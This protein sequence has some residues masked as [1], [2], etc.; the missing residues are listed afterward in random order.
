MSRRV[1]VAGVVLAALVAVAALRLPGA[2]VVARAGAAAPGEVDL[3]LAG[4]VTRVVDGDTA[5]VRV[6][7]GPLEVRFYGIDA[8]EGR[9]PFGREAR[10]ALERRIAGRRVEIVPVEQDQYARMVAVVLVDGASVNEA[11]L[12]D[13]LAWAYRN[14]LGQVR[15][16]ENFC[17]L[18]DRARAAR[19]GLWSQPPERWVPPWVYRQ[20]SRAAPGAAFPS[21]DYANETAAD[22]AAAVR[23]ARQRRRA[24]PPPGPASG[25]PAA[26]AAADAVPADRRPGCDI[27]GN[28]N[29]KG[30]RIYHL[31]GGEW[32][33]GTRID[34]ARGE[35]WFCSE[36]EAQSAGWRPAR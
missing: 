34:A 5:W 32:Y 6:D 28:I 35:R 18:E 26:A 22:C 23:A 1:L 14:Y 31:P 10:Q 7:S 29:A 4:T 27:K 33:D 16:D 11:M 30:A 15:G 2:G 20:R 8:P 36:Q 9:A 3:V 24:S 19:K 17:E 13:G 12:A 25:A 21:R